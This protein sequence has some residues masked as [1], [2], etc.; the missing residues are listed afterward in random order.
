MMKRE[1]DKLIAPLVISEEDYLE[2][3]NIYMCYPGIEDKQTVATLYRLLGMKIF[4]DMEKR[5]NLASDCEK[6][7]RRLEAKTK[8]IMTERI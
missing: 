7:Q 8:S 2:V 1:F 3:E 6:E 5:A 4:Y